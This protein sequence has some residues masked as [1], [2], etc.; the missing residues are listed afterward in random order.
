MRSRVV[1]I[2]R[3]AKVKCSIDQAKRSFDRAANGIFAKIGRLAS[4]EVIVQFFK[5]MCLP[6]LPY[7]LE[8][9]LGQKINAVTGLTFNIFLK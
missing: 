9:Q 6:I 1:I 8:V 3:P 5:Q 2:V 4:E 7:A